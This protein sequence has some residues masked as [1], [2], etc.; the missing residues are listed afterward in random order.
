MPKDTRIFRV[1]KEGYRKER[2]K[3][4]TRTAVSGMFA[5]SYHDDGRRPDILRVEAIDPADI[6][7]TDVT[8][9]FRNKPPV[10]CDYHR[11][12]NGKIKPRRMRDEDMLRFYKRCCCWELYSE[13]HP[14]Y[15][16]H[17]GNCDRKQTDPASCPC[18]MAKKIIGPVGID[19]RYPWLY[20]AHTKSEAP[21][22]T[23]PVRSA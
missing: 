23:Q 20:R 4:A 10:K 22:R 5:R 1:I 19:P 18:Q 8:D 6:E 9:E 21:D 12:Y 2:I 3:Y 11:G 7:W 17:W 14:E 16:A 15:P 13:S